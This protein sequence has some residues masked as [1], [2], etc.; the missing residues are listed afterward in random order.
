MLDV[1]QGLAIVVI[2]REHVLVYD[3]GAKF[4]DDFSMVTAVVQPFLLQRGV[5]TINTLVISHNDNDHA[6]N[7]LSLRDQFTVDQVMMG[8]PLP[9]Q[10]YGVLPCLAGQQWQW[11]GIDYA[12][13]HP[14]TDTTYARSNNRS[15][16]LKISSQQI[17]FL[18]AGDIEQ[19][20]ET[21]MVHNLGPQLASNVLIAPH[22]GSHSSSSWPW[23]KSVAAEYVVFSSGYRNQ[24]SHPRPD[25]QQRYQQVD[26]N[27]L[28]S[29]QT[30]ALTF[31]V[32]Q[33]KLL[34]PSAYR[35]QRR[36][37]WL[38]PVDSD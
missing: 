25:I 22:H 10:Q 34:I 9:Y 26:S 37:Y 28:I 20:V 15:C 23:V 24:F 38:A 27:T 35:Q 32:R 6:G 18:L 31:T 30:G 5:E 14:Q 2:S 21:L 3:V 16:V 13:L 1:G 8:D 12:V 29:H 36:R 33:G 11:D 4:S 7:W 17:G 19:S